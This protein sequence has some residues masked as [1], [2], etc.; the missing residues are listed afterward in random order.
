MN[1]GRLVN[2]NQEG[3]SQGQKIHTVKLMPSAK[4]LFFENIYGNKTHCNKFLTPPIDLKQTRASKD[5]SEN[6]WA[7]LE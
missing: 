4:H 3:N 1:T 2:I 5:V 6:Y 7:Y